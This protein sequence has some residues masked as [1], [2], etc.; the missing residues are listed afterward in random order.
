[1]GVVDRLKIIGLMRILIPPIK[2]PEVVY[3]LL[4]V[5]REN[6]KNESSLY[7]III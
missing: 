1:M 5:I 3:F 2:G 6:N 7:N 4:A